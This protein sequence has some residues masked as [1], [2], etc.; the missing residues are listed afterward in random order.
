MTRYRA[1]DMVSYGNHQG[2]V[3][4]AAP[5]GWSGQICSVQFGNSEHWI[6]ADELELVVVRLRFRP[7]VVGGRDHHPDTLPSEITP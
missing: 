1:G 2:E 5:C 6:M 7:R 4:I 3:V